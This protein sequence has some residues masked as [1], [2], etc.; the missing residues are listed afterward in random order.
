LRGGLDR[1]SLELPKSPLLS[2]TSVQYVDGSGALQTLDPSQYLVDTAT[3]PGRVTPA[4]GLAW[5]VARRQMDA[6]RVT[7]VA[8]HPVTNLLS[9]P[10]AAGVQAVTPASMAGILAGS[11][12]AVGSGATR[13]RVAV[14]S[15]T[16]TTFTAN[17]P[18]AAFP[19]DAVSGLPD[20]LRAG[21]LLLVGGWYVHREAVDLSNLGPLPLGAEA[22]LGVAS[23]GAYP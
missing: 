20:A 9:A 14:S 2:V 17:F 12:L 4:F 11:V 1:W 5:P 15:V 7:F 3:K 8:G 21:L 10:G 13:Q 16:A 23:T 18:R 22:L 6:V 19:G